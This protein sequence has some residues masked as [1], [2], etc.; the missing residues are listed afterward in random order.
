MHFYGCTLLMVQSYRVILLTLCCVCVCFHFI[1]KDLCRNLL[2][3]TG[4]MLS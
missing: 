2:V 1:H 3:G 4:K